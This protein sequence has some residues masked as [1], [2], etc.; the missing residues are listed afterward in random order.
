[1]IESLMRGGE[2]REAALQAMIDVLHGAGSV[3]ASLVFQVV[4]RLPRD[5]QYLAEPLR[6]L[7][8]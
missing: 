2:E 1:M 8:A 6:K 7:A 3:E 4:D 5:M